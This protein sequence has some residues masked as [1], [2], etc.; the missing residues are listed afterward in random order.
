[1]PPRPLHYQRAA[2]REIVV[3]ER[4]DMHL[5]WEPNKIYLKPLPRYLLSH[6]FWKENLIC[7][8]TCS[9]AGSTT[10]SATDPSNNKPSA[11]KKPSP[12]LSPPLH[13]KQQTT[14]QVSGRI[15]QQ[16]QLYD[17]AYGL[18]SSYVALIQ[19]ESDFR[20]AQSAFLL[21][22]TVTWTIW[23]RL[24]RQLLDE[25]NGKRLPN[26]RFFF[27][28]LRLNRLNMIYRVRFGNL[29]GYRLGYQ[30]YGSF[31]VDNLAP[32]VSIITYMVVVLTAMQVGLA[33]D[34]L[35][36]NDIF[37]GA[38]Y[39]FTIFSILFPPF[40]IAL[41]FCWFLTLFVNNVFA[42]LSFK[43]KRLTYNHRS[44]SSV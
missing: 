19:Y 2:S 4:I 39:G 31:F 37:Q 3:V 42:T 18:L 11:A 35:G 20:I 5:V 14:G 1:M 29:R 16:H 17:C 44:Q 30:T 28:E 25:K 7:K 9:C 26:K 13:S 6:K 33:T 22:E 43:K 8:P 40:F 41:F 32:I 12:Q 15:C 38:S 27:G 34:R 21:P 24:V 23:K 36:G 10:R